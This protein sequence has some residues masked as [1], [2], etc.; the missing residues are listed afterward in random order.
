M[1]DK[2]IPPAPKTPPLSAKTL[3]PTRK[4]H[5]LS[6]KTI[7]VP[8]KTHL[9]PPKVVLRREVNPFLL[10]VSSACVPSHLCWLPSW[11]FVMYR[12][13]PSPLSCVPGCLTL[14]AC[15]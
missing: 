13:F 7:P 11:S 5:S 12:P 4:T 8:P 9:L 1:P 3:P 6:A 10:G 15:I 2:T 14:D